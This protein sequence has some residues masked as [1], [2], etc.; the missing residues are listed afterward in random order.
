MG[1]YIWNPAIIEI[2]GH[3]KYTGLSAMGLQVSIEY[4]ATVMYS[5]FILQLSG[6]SAS[7][8]TALFDFDFFL[9]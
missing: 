4:W 7:H 9:F 1:F 8:L 3:K 6:S 5:G 2:L